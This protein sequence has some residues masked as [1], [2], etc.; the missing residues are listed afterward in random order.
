MVI[1]PLDKTVEIDFG[2]HAS[3]VTDLSN[4]DITLNIEKFE[5]TFDS[6]NNSIDISYDH[7]PLASET[8]P[9]KS[10]VYAFFASIGNW[11][12]THCNCS[13]SCACGTCCCCKK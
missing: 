11:F 12:S 7:V 4:N 2:N 3:I 8:L 5:V 13:S 1:N 6:S 9:S 10:S